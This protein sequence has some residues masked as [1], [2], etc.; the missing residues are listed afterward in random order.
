MFNWTTSSFLSVGG[1]P[2]VSSAAADCRDVV[3]TIT[4]LQIDEV[5]DSLNLNYF[6]KVDQVGLVLV[7]CWIA[8]GLALLFGAQNMNT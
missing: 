1:H 7:S 8:L 3:I 4:Y 2:P 6:N 5:K